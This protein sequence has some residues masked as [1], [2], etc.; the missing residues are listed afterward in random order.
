MRDYP[1]SG[2][3]QQPCDVEEICVPEQ[4]KFAAEEYVCHMLPS[5][6]N[7]CFTHSVHIRVARDAQSRDLYQTFGKKPLFPSVKEVVVG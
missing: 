5:I 3:G 2:R 6:T 1:F 4:E 7:D